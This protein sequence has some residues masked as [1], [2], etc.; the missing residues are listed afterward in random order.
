MDYQISYHTAKE[1]KAWASRIW[2]ALDERHRR[3]LFYDTEDTMKLEM[4]HRALAGCD[5]FGVATQGH[6]VLAIAWVGRIVPHSRC[7]YAHFAYIDKPIDEITAEFLTGIQSLH[8]Y[9]SILTVEPLSYRGARAHAIR[10]GFK[11]LAQIPGLI[12]WANKRRT[13]STGVLL[14]KDLR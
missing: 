1:G 10:H 12:V 9:D 4:F 5:I 7:A 3:T 6:D 14:Y 8:I 13:P 11:V 2:S